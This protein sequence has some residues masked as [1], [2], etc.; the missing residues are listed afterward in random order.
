MSLTESKQ[1]PTKLII[2]VLLE[3]DRVTKGRFEGGGQI[4]IRRTLGIERE[5][6][7]WVVGEGVRPLGIVRLHAKLPVRCINDVTGERGQ[8]LCRLQR[9]IRQWASTINSLGSGPEPLAKAIGEQFVGQRAAATGAWGLGGLAVFTVTLGRG[10]NGGR[11][12][13]DQGRFLDRSRRGLGD[14]TWDTTWDGDGD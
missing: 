13:G 3:E 14:I 9:G 6:P 1:F 11:M 8:N 5:T 10:R 4:D 7:Q 2:K 12:L